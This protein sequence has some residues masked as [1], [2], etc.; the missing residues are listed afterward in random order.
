MP[1]DTRIA[2]L[3]IL[4]G[5]LL[6]LAGLV[7]L[8]GAWPSWLGRLPGDIRIERPGFKLYVPLTSCLLISLLL[9]ALAWLA[10]R[11]LP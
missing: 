1:P 4:L 11:W 3:L 8:A 2:W 7:W 6:V 9:T 10:R 5:L